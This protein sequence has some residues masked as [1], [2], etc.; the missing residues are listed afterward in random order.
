MTK[1]ENF[2][3]SFLRGPVPFGDPSPGGDAMSLAR[4]SDV[5]TESQLQ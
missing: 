4:R 5:E 1:L 2:L 3:K